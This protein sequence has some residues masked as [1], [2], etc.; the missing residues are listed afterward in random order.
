MKVKSTKWFKDFTSFTKTWSVVKGIAGGLI[1]LFGL[2][3]LRDS[4]KL[5]TMNWMVNEMDDTEVEDDFDE[6]N[7]FYE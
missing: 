1:T 2:K 4:T 7:K 3:W 5:N 6:K